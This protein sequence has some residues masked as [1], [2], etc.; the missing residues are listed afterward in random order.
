MTTLFIRHGR[1]RERRVE[2]LG[3]AVIGGRR[4]HVPMVDLPVATD[5]KCF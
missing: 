3:V 1:T 4:T 2:I 5:L